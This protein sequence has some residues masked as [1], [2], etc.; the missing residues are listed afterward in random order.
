[1]SAVQGLKRTPFTDAYPHGV[2]EWI[3]VFGY[4]TPVTWGDPGAEY[5]AVRN[6]AAAMDFSMLL[7]WDVRGPTAV[8]VV[9]R[10]FSRDVARQKPGRIS[11]G[12]VTSDSGTMV[13]D[14]TVFV[15]GPEHV[16]MFGANP[17]VGEFLVAQAPESVTVTQRRDDLADLSVQGPKSREILQRLTGTDLSNAALPYYSFVT[18]IEL[19][20]IPA[21]ISR[22]GYTGELGFEVL[23][24]ADRAVPFWDAL[25]E[26]GSG[27]GLV[28]A[29]AA[30][31]M[32]CRIEAGMIMGELE[33]DE[34]VTPYE[35]RMGWAVDLRKMEFQG[36]SAL[37]RAKDEPRLDVV[38]VVLSDE[39]EYDGAPLT[40]AGERI[41]HV[42][43]AIPSPYLDGRI[44]GLA[45]IDVKH[46]APGSVLDV[47]A[48]GDR[49]ATI[50]PMPVYDPERTRVRR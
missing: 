31:V 42:T 34:T 45:R 19:A 47:G 25:F 36:R 26:A 30:T 13:D 12:V 18:G 35:C 28:P 33:Y 2:A 43:M 3:D 8:D 44:L 17:R 24:A 29:G 37:A 14:C 46:A 1:M 7:K 16:R 32:M 39:G 23:V 15:H 6:N 10:V 22:I 5:D 50:V 11:Y 40:V 41:G 4:A 21:Q 48:D 38:S 9:N 27:D 20:G 49:T